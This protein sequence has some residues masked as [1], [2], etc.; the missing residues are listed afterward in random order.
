MIRGDDDLLGVLGE[1]S[2]STT[3][4][5]T[6]NE[7]TSDIKPSNQSLKNEDS[8]KS[9]IRLQPEV[10]G[11]HNT[12]TKTSVD[13]GP[14]GDIWNPYVFVEECTGLSSTDSTTIL[15]PT[16]PDVEVIRRRSYEKFKT[17][18]YAAF[19]FISSNDHQAKSNKDKQ[20]KNKIKPTSET[21]YQ[22]MFNTIWKQIPPHNILERFHFACKLEESMRLVQKIHLEGKKMNI[23]LKDDWSINEIHTLQTKFQESE[24]VMDPI[25]LSPNFSL[26]RNQKKRN[27]KDRQKGENKNKYKE[28]SNL[29]LLKN[30]IEFQF[31]REFKKSSNALKKDKNDEN[32]VDDNEAMSTLKEYFASTSFHRKCKKISNEIK[33]LSMEVEREFIVQVTKK[34]AEVATTSS[35]NL[36]NSKKI[37][38]RKGVPKV[39]LQDF[40]SEGSSFILDENEEKT[41]VMEVTFAGLTFRISVPHY[42]K[43]QILFDRNNTKSSS[44]LDHRETFFKALFATL[45]RYDML[46]GGGLQSALSG[47]VFDV[48]LKQFNCNMECFASPFNCRYERYCSVFPDTDMIFGSMGSFFDFNFESLRNGGC[49]QANPPFAADFILAMYNRIEK[50]LTDESI[51]A[52][53]MFIV[54]IPAWMYSPGWQA[55]SKSSVLTKSILLSQKDDPHYYCE[56]TQHR[57]LKDRYRVASFDTSVF[58]LQNKAAKLKWD[59]SDK[60]IHELKKAFATNPNEEERKMKSIGSKKRK[61]EKLSTGDCKKGQQCIAMPKKSTSNVSQKQKGKRGK[62]ICENSLRSSKGKK[63]K[64]LIDNTSQQF[65]ILSGILGKSS[66]R[67][68]TKQKR[69]S[70]CI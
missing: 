21:N 29:D 35:N 51:D 48:L 36:S 68:S 20:T 64:K 13:N 63:K 24:I 50:L 43:L 32:G 30:E 9:R 31:S 15:I 11:Y 69:G 12:K 16:N 58:F 27:S 44:S 25:L 17:K 8:S 22:E 4:L 38:R 65:D 49:F 55:L 6:E 37:R 53:F 18:F 14:N 46:E 66:T 33:D 47:H 7:Q 70:S 1:M 62:K 42:N 60:C 67:D 2:S 45:C 23:Q 40:S 34:A 41:E 5:E 56:G 54:F 10:E 57:R 61:V 19:R 52:P 39:S 26:Q 28:K 59:L 3:P